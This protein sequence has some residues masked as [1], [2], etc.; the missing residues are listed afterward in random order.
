MSLEVLYPPTTSTNLTN[1]PVLADLDDDGDLD[2]AV[3]K[4]PNSTTPTIY[5]NVGGTFVEALTFPIVGTLGQTTL[6]AGDS[7]GGGFGGS[8]R[9]LQAA[10]STR[11]ART[12][13]RGDM[14]AP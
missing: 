14:S 13:E 12:N 11:L 10:S 2:L 1:Q 4:G 3:D 9:P 8:W 5:E 7:F 6:A